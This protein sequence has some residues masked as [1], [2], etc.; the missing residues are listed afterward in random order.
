MLSA[1]LLQELLAR[2]ALRDL[3]APEDP[4]SVDHLEGR[5]SI[6]DTELDVIYPMS[7]V[8][9]SLQLTQAKTYRFVFIGLAGTDRLESLEPFRQR[10]DSLIKET[11]LQR[12]PLQKGRFRRSYW[13]AMHRAEFALC[14]QRAD[15]PGS[16]ERA[17]TY[18][19]IEATLTWSIP[20]LFDETP[21]GAD[22]V[23]N[24]HY[25]NAKT[26]ESAVYDREAAI[27]N[28]RLTLERHVLPPNLINMLAE[29]SKPIG[30]FRRH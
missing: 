15:W 11:R 6:G 24:F 18:R 25:V 26:A 16:R 14:P 21:L 13:E 3:C 9:R 10:H 20:V 27:R 12:L 22:F 19:F 4:L 8:S 1:P 30:G 7:W 23:R 2:R 28:F 29:R 17:W 5:N